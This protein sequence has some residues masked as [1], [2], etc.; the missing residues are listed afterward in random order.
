[1]RAKGY[2]HGRRWRQRVWLRG[3]RHGLETHGTPFHGQPGEPD[4]LGWARAAL[5][6]GL[7]LRAV[8]R[9]CETAPNTV[10]S[11]LVAAAE[12][13]E[14]FSRPCVHDLDV[15]QGQRDELLALLSAVKD[16]EGSAPQAMQRLSRSPHW[17]GVAMDPVGT[18]ILA[19]A[20]G[21]RPLAMAHRLVHQGTQ[22]RA[23]HC[24]PR[25]R[26]DGLRESLPAL[27]THDGRWMHPERRQSQGPQPHPHWRPLAGLLYAQVVKRY[28]RRRIVGGTHRVVFGAHET[29]HQLLAKR[30]EDQHAFRRAAQPG[31]APAGGGA[32]SAGQHILQARR[33]VATATNALPGLS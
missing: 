24:A 27:G 25:L 30:G 23:P 20:V 1:M 13:L 15:E 18:L 6:E 31:L 14:A 33:R 22:V 26:T 32:W 9:V 11:W 12:P 2:P 3:K 21:D 5:A 10:L 16:G 8:G 19:V 7:G 17:V 28:R 4:Q 29:I